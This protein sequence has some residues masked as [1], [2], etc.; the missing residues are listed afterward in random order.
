MA[1]ERVG[2][3]PEHRV[4]PAGSD[5]REGLQHKGPLMRE[6]MRKDERPGAGPREIPSPAPPVPDDAFVVY[7]VDVERAWSP[8]PAPAPPGVPL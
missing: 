5:I 6:R 8:G 1:Q 2:A 4:T 3:L 7:D